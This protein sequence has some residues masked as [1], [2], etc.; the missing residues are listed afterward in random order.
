MQSD[1]KENGMIKA[2][3]THLKQY[4]TIFASCVQHMAGEAYVWARK[5]KETGGPLL[6]L[7]THAGRFIVMLAT[8]GGPRAQ[9]DP[10]HFAMDT[11]YVTKLNRLLQKRFG[12]LYFGDWHSHVLYIDHPSNGDQEHIC[13][14]A[15]RHNIPQMVQIILTS[16]RVTDRQSIID[17]TKMRI[18]TFVYH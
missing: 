12:I 18:N 14:L 9:R 15:R 6:G 8:S 17:I 11:E 1:N 5:G 3:Y 16:E 13:R 2:L 4:I 10:A 7:R